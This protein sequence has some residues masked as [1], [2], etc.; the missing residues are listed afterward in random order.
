[1]KAKH[2]L[3]AALLFLLFT[4]CGGGSGGVAPPTEPSIV[5]PPD[6]GLAGK[7][8]LEGIDTDGDGIR[9][10][11]QIAIFERYPED[12]E[13]RAAL[14]QNVRA[15]QT[16]LVV[17]QAGDPELV[18]TVSEYMSKGLYCLFERGIEEDTQFLRE[19]VLNT[20]ARF[21]ADIKFNKLLNGQFFG[22]ANAIDPCE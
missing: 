17:S 6:P 5:L 13:K 22:S 3:F 18:H 19:Q 15:L 16:A 20:P 10:E 9:D 8:T 2:G 7:A 21:E 1:M 4:G 11:L 12:G 14:F